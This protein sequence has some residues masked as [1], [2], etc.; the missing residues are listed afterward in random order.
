MSAEDP[1]ARRAVELAEGGRWNEALSH[2]QALANSATEPAE[3]ADHLLSQVRC[4]IELRRLSEA[5]ARFAEAAELM[6]DS[7]Q[8]RQELSFC[9]V[10]LLIAEQKLE[11]ALENL[12][13]L[14]KDYAA[15]SRVANYQSV[16]QAMEIRRG[17]VLAGLGRF[18]EALPILET[19]LCYDQV[20][21][22]G[23]FHYSLAR[24][25]CERKEFEQAKRILLE[26]F[27]QGYESRTKMQAHFLLGQV[28]YNQ[29]AFARALQEFEVCESQFEELGVSRKDFFLWLEYSSAAL[30]QEDRVRKYKRMG[31]S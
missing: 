3:R 30:G 15:Y 16:W 8:T 11:R 14:H 22:N 19:A 4:L 21:K 5:R 18:R 23:A 7:P 9:E 17:L 25:Y 13:Q 12:E 2:L 28:H 20:E 29:G 27:K 6:A 31:E 10:D 26:G 1:R 24:C